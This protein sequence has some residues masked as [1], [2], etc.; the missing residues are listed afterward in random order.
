MQASSDIENVWDRTGDQS[1]LEIYDLAQDTSRV[2]MEF[3]QVIEA[4][5]WTMDGRSLVY[6]S[7]GRIYCLDLETLAISELDTG[8]VDQCNND[9][10]L[11]PDGKLIAVSHATEED[12]KSRIYTVP[13]SGGVPNL[14][15][16]LAPSYL[17]GWSPDGEEL[18]YCA[19]RGGE[20]DIYVIPAQGGVERK[21]TCEPGLSDGP[22]Y[23]PSGK[24]I[25]FNAA[26][27]GSMQV[28]RMNRDGSEQTR[29]TYDEDW[30]A[31]FPHISPNGEHVVYLVYHHTDVKPDEHVPNKHV[32]L[33]L[34]D[35]EGGGTRTIVKLFGGQGTINVN[36]W[37][38]DSKQ[39]AYVRYRR[40][41]R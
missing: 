7:E 9:H 3:D 39:F 8:Y 31:W 38:P 15:T 37:S 10:V 35:Y 32:E 19:E 24:H 14:I 30:Y 34:M 25:W 36:S 29:M 6:N 2:V 22:E 1:I 16:P 21:L 23:D 26:R 4:P 27:D 20:Y 40:G 17:H 12:G 11:S 28:Y 13:L 33:R 41:D 5:N 18:A